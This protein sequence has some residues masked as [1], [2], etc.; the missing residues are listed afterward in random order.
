MILSVKV[1]QFKEY[2]K[3]EICQVGGRGVVPVVLKLC[4]NSKQG[5]IILMLEAVINFWPLDMWKNNLIFAAGMNNSMV[6][7][8]VCYAHL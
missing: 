7:I 1:F 5:C 3:K 2:I 6:M 8:T 4:I